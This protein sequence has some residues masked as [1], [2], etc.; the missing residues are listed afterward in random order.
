MSTF[1]QR[2]DAGAARRKV[3]RRAAWIENV[4]LLRQRGLVFSV[5]DQGRKIVLRHDGRV[6]DFWPATSKWRLR[7]RI[8][9]GDFLVATCSIREG[10]TIATMFALMNLAPDLCSDRVPVDPVGVDVVV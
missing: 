2:T 5:T 3:A 10:K 8:E 4:R 1:K 6:F 9:G 7:P